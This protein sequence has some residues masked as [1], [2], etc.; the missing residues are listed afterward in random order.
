MSWSPLQLGGI[1]FIS[2]HK[3]PAL[4]EFQEGLNVVRGAS[5]TG[6]SF[7]VEAINFLLGARVDRNNNPLRDI[8]QRDGYD[9]ARLIL[10]ARE[11]EIFT[12]Q[13][14]TD[15]GNFNRFEGACLINE[16]NIEA[17]SLRAVH[18]HGNHETLSTY[19]LSLIGLE[20]KYVQKNSRGTTQSLSFRN[21]VRLVVVQENDIT[22]QESP[23]LSGRPTDATV[24]YSVFKLLLTGVDAS[25]LAEQDRIQSEIATTRQNNRAKLEFIEELIQEQQ[26][27][28]E[29]IEINRTQAEEQISSLETQL[30]RQQNILAQFRQNLNSLIEHRRSISEQKESV[31]SRINEITSLLSRFELLK[32]HYH[33]DIER[34]TSIE[35]SGSLFVYLERTSCPL[36]GAL[37]NEQHQDE[38]C[39]GDIESIV[40]AAAAEMAKVQQLSKELDQTIEDLITEAKELTNQREQFEPDLQFLNQE[41][42]EINSPINDVQNTFSELVR[43]SSEVRRIVDL[44]SRIE[45]MQQKRD[46][47][48]AEINASSNTVNL[49]VDLSTSVL[50]DYAKTVQKLLHAWNFPGWERVS[51]D[52]TRKDLVI[53]GQPRTSRGKGLRSVTHAAM[54]IGLMDFCKERN[55]SHPG[56]VVLD[57]PLLAYWQPEASEDKALLEG[58]GLKEKFYE[59]LANNY[60]DSQI[61]IIE[62]E[63]PPDSIEGIISLMNFTGN[64]NEGRSGF[65]PATEN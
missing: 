16:P 10:R 18:E 45:Q 56:F 24:D 30:R 31:T 28:L 52:E 1:S 40:N 36:C 3:P 13:R 54:T 8:P 53:G 17:T 39:D 19:L 15:G 34:L 50:D 33:I 7:M 41:I 11:N 21:L 44:F 58:V 12:L 26:A 59:Y 6:K 2:P 60:N 5:D 48:L 4:L 29:G 35:E 14:S 32:E 64:P 62:N 57:S 25:A 23:I 38:M 22:K 55:L 27:Q 63:R 49:R 37:P 65:F 20:N 43:Q 47:L 51:F 46:S 61:L 42:Q 9:R